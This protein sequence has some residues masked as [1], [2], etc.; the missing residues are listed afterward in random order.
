[1]ILILNCCSGGLDLFEVR[2]FL[3][4]LALFACILVSRIARA[5]ILFY[6]LLRFLPTTKGFVLAR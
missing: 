6:F 1:M 3:G 4:N 5:F 2:V